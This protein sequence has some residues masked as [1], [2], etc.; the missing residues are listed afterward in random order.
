MPRKTL[1]RITS[2]TTGKRP[3]T[4]KIVWKDGAQTTADVSGHIHAYA[5]YAPLRKA[6][7]LF[8]IV[9]PGEH[10]T[11]IQWTDD[12]DMSA[13]T[14]MRLAREQAGLT[15]SSSDFKSW[16]QRQALTLDSAAKAL[17]LSRRSVAY[18]E[19]GEKPIPR[20]VALATRALEMA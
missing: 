13:D 17:G 7:Q 16:R 15:M 12:I 2:V 4:L 10:G 3:W 18:Y 1:P 20:V 14:L 11:D 19:Q 9:K 5:L 8:H 6:P